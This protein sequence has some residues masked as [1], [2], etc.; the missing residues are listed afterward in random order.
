MKII[1][2]INK[3]QGVD[4]SFWNFKQNKLIIHYQDIIPLDTLKIRVL[5]EVGKAGLQRA[6]ET[7][8]F[9]KV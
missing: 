3:I 1:D 5:D 9:Y 7:I 2:R 8:D 6:I 4:M